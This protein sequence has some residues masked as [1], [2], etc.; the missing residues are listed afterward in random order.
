M[1]SERSSNVLN[2]IVSVYGILYFLSIIILFFSKSKTLTHPEMFTA[3]MAFLLYIVGTVYC[4]FNQKTGGY[5]LL[6]WHFIIWLFVTFLWSK[7]A[8]I[9]VLAFPILAISVLLIRDWFKNNNPNFS[10][11]IQQW[12]LVLRILLINYVV[13][14][15]LV[16]FSDVAASVL[17]I[18]LRGDATSVNTWNFNH[19]ETSILIFELLLFMLAAV[20]SLKSGLTGGL[21]LIAWYIILTISCYTYPR[22]GN[23]GPWTL[24]S[25]PIFAQGLLYLILYFKEKKEI[26]LL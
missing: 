26:A 5:I 18:H 10:G 12:K 8:L 19:L 20:F 16:V 14:Y 4:W 15:F 13:I 6:V 23:S 1:K 11:S 7:A 25:I 21:L 22:I 9:L 17:G 2:I 24:F 3:P